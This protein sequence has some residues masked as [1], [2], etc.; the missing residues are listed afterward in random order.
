[1]SNNKECVELG[2][3]TREVAK[4]RFKQFPIAILPVGACEQHGP[5]LPLD[6]DAFDA[7]YLAVEGAKKVSSPKPLVLPT[8]SYGV[9]LHH[10]AFCGTVSITPQT[11]MNI[12][13]EIAESL[14]EHKVKALLV[15][16]G[17]G[18]NTAS[19]SAAG[20]LIKHKLKM[21]YYL[22]EGSG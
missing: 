11:L 10:L 16:N 6:T 19:L 4:K 14:A 5:H 7:Y 22:Y 3:V 9:S 21:E 18:G 15:V 20:Q 17:H 1:M 2:E 13:Y 8:L 12:V